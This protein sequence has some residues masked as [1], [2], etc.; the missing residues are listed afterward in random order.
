MEDMEKEP[1]VEEAKVVKEEKSE[2][3]NEIH[4]SQ[5]ALI[6]CMALIAMF[7]FVLCKILFNFGVGSNTFYGIMSIVVYGLPLAG[8]IWSY[9]SAKKF[10]LEFWLNVIVFGLAI[11]LF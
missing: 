9:L 4:F 2:P 10:T 6:V 8:L 5:Q 11:W 7:L 3:K 1:Q